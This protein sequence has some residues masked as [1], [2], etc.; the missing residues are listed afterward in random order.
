MRTIVML[1]ALV[2]A[3]V[4]QQAY[5]TPNCN[6]YLR[7]MDNAWGDP[8]TNMNFGRWN[9]PQGAADPPWVAH[10]PENPA[11][12]PNSRHDEPLLWLV[13]G[14]VGGD[15]GQLWCHVG[16]PLTS[17]PSIAGAGMWQIDLTAGILLSDFVWVGSPAG[18][19]LPIRVPSDWRTHLTIQGWAL[20]PWTP[21][22]VSVSA[23]CE[24]WR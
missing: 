23:A 20:T 10:L 11:R 16:P 15:P 2:A 3:A 12:I 24:I 22:G 5:N 18:L 19:I 14:G 9:I 8:W 1:A 7:A 13:L 17:G 4:G 21:N 6:L